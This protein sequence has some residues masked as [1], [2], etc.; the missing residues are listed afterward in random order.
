MDKDLKKTFKRYDLVKLDN[1][2]VLEKAKSR[3]QIKF[4]AYGR[5]FEFDLTPNDLRAAGYKAVATTDSGDYELGQTEVITYKGKLKNDPDS[6]VRFTLTEETMEGFIYTGDEKFFVNKAR[7][8]SKRAQKDDVVVYSENDLVQTIDLSN[9]IEGKLD[10]GLEYMQGFIYD[11]AASTTLREVEVATEA[12]YQWVTQSG[13]ASAANNEILGILNNVDGIYRRDLN[14]TVRVTFQHAW[15]TPDPFSASSSS[16]LLNSFLSY[17]NSTYPASTYRRDT[18]HLFTGKLNNQG[19]AYQGIMCQYTSYAYGLTGRSGS[20]N[21]LIAAHEIG[22]NLGADHVDN[23]GT[24]AS[25]LMNPSI[26]FSAT[27]FCS[28]SKT[29]IGNFVNTYGSCLSAAGTTTPTPTPTPVWTPTPTPTPVW[30]PTPTPTPVWTPTPTPTPWWTPTPTPT[31][32]PS[33]RTNVALST[34]GGF[35]SAS[36]VSSSSYSPH[37]AIDGARNWA[38]SAGWRDETMDVFPDWLQID[39]NGSKTIDQINVYAVTDDYWNPVDPDENTVATLY[40]ITSFDVQYW[41]GSGWIT[42]PNGSITNN[43]KALKKIVFSPITTS[44]IRVVVKDAL[45]Y[46]R[47]VEVEAWSGGTVTSTPTPTPT[48]WATPTPTAT[49]PPTATPT[50]TVNPTPTV[51][52]NVALST[53]GGFASASS[54]SSSAYAAGLANDGARNWAISAGWR[55]ASMDVFPDW[56]QIDFNGSKTISEVHIYAV[57]DD[58]WNPVDPNENTVATL[59]GITSFD[60]QY[61]NGSGWIT[62]PNGAVTNNDKALKK[63]VFSPITTSRIRVVVKDALRYSRIVE[64]E[65]WSGG[66]GYGE[67]EAVSNNFDGNAENA[68]F[69]ERLKGWSSYFVG[70][71]NSLYNS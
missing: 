21:H 68:S 17:W 27:A 18:A 41:N 60:V 43:D 22:H 49:P 28:S 39:F 63:I 9:D 3:Q 44:R 54:V 38:T 20:V 42:V 46:S 59:Y 51:R 24:C 10:L 50:P 34:N 26:S 37:L 25:S 14:L 71:Y 66:T 5:D 12:D 67:L 56:L 35:A 70:L 31:P 23:S 52:T 55:D 1:H 6:E 64:V 45:R 47:I 58:Y 65:A 57:T 61:W 7:N 15:S 40:G 19:I 30:T 69:T 11:E 62:V 29:Q 16:A 2:A 13:G 48:P 4:Q 53:N 36:S 8:F 32:T 33:T